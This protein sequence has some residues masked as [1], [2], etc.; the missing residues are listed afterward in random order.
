[1]E[2]QSNTVK[3]TSTSQKGSTTAQ[4]N[5]F[6]FSK[7]EETF[8]NI[9]IPNSQ[10]QAKWKKDVGYSVGIENVKLTRD[11]K[12]LEQAL[13]QIGYG[14]DIDKDGDE[15]LVKLE[16]IDFEIIPRIV[17]ALIILNEES[18]RAIIE[19]NNLKNKENETNN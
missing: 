8:R 7:A 12:T 19:E 15:I 11:Y 9:T 13:N 6:D 16:G 1:M 10:F 3:N 14:V 4:G 18:P 5:S 17:K 2:K